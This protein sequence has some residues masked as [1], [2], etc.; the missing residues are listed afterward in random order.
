VAVVEALPGA[1]GYASVLQID[2]S[3]TD[4]LSVQA[5]LSNCTGQRPVA[6]YAVD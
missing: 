2:V 1:T 6:L 4:V 5:V 3:L